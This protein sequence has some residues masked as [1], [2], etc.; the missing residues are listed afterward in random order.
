K[1]SITKNNG[2]ELTAVTVCRK[3]YSVSPTI[4]VEAYYEQYKDTGNLEMVM[5]S[6]YKSFE[7]N[8][9]ERKIN[10]DNYFDF[11]SAKDNIVFRLV[12]RNMNEKN[13]ANIP[14]VIFEDLAV[15]FRWVVDIGDESMSSVLISN[16]DMVRWN[17]NVQTLYDL[18]MNNTMRMFPLHIENLFEML[19]R[20]FDLTEYSDIENEKAQLFIITNNVGINGAAAILYS[21]A[22]ERCSEETGGSIY[23]MPSSIHEMLFVSAEYVE[24][25]NELKEL[26]REANANVVCRTEVLSDNV[27]Y[28]DYTKKTLEIVH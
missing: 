10:L 18:A 25:V 21:G 2:L 7:D 20:R 19:S 5:Q 12:N 4:Y 26:V 16:N 28:Y 23:I 6:I 9:Y 14:S 13:L 22:L 1:N 17:T 3:N 27:Y 8:M 11:E 15:T 24:N